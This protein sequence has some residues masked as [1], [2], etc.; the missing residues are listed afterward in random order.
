MST[1]KID[2]AIALWSVLMPLSIDERVQTLV[3]VMTFL[4]QSTIEDSF[5]LGPARCA[6][7]D[8]WERTS[9][10]AIPIREFRKMA[11]EK[12][13]DFMKVLGELASAETTAEFS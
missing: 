2:E 3:E 9:G 10:S 13:G 4:P 11:E 5:R 8:F 6:L 12:R 7:A 1:A